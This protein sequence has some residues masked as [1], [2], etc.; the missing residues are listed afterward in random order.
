MTMSDE[1]TTQRVTRFTT[2]AEQ[3]R[4]FA[5]RMEQS[6]P[7]RMDHVTS[8]ALAAADAA[9]RAAAAYAAGDKAAATA[10]RAE[11]AELAGFNGTHVGGIN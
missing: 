7:G 3:I 4:A 9:D 1:I 6:A 8:R 5:D 2:L 11:Y 10:A